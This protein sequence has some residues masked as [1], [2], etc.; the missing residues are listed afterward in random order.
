MT[1]IE[2]Y[3]KWISENPKKVCNKVKTMYERLTKDIGDIIMKAC[4]TDSVAVYVSGEHSCMTTRGIK[5][6]GSKTISTY[7]T[8][9]FKNNNYSINLVPVKNFSDAINYLKK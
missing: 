4:E 1:Y 3:N 5:K 7:Y 6:N 2:E 8:G 9:D